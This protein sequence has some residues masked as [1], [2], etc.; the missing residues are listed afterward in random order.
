MSGNILIKAEGKY[1]YRNNNS[2]VLNVGDGSV[3]RNSL[4]GPN[5]TDI[6]LVLYDNDEVGIHY[7]ISSESIRSIGVLISIISS[8]ELTLNCGFL[9]LADGYWKMVSL[10]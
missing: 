3:D 7:N 5:S 10:N 2:D 1:I 6:P 9:Y 8:V 4:V